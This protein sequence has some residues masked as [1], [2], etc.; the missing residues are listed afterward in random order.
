MT[1]AQ[2][3]IFKSLKKDDHRNGFIELLMA[4]QTTLGSYTHWQPAYLKKL[5][6]KKVAPM[7]F[8][9]PEE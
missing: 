9:L 2:K 4:Q 6:K 1:K 7:P 5:K 3:S 8:L